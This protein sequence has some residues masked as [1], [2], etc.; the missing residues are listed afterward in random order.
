MV[1]SYRRQLALLYLSELAARLW[2]GQRWDSLGGSAL[3]YLGS[4][5]GSRLN[6]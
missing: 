5:P 3:V 1:Y 6:I 4:R 2:A